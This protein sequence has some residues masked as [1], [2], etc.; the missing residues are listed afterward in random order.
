MSYKIKLENVSVQY[1]MPS[2]RIGTLKEYVIRKIQGKVKH[3]KFFA[4]KNVNLEINHGEVF[5]VIG[6]NGAGKST[7]LK[8]FA[9]VLPPSIGRI[10]I[11]GSVSPLLELGAGF[12]PELSGRENVYLNGAL[13]G[14]SRDQMRK[15]FND[16]VEFSGLSDFI[17]API[18]TYSSGMW[19]R[20]GFAVATAN[21]P[22]ILLVDEILAVGDEAF[23]QKC[24]E[25]I[26]EFKESGT[27]IV[28]VAHS[29][30]TI[31]EQ[32]SRVGWIDHGE[33]K[34]LGDPEMAIDLYRKSQNR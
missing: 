20:L 32:S 14:F 5:G 16:I 12:H 25:R 26:N 4:L 27:I 31:L 13:L 18:R 33:M 29:M 19:A 15:K 7:M 30:K 11:H 21:R 10:E 23:Q 9:R 17:D 22:D 28:I 1:R 6:H 24:F 34:F 8:L 3:R 2:E